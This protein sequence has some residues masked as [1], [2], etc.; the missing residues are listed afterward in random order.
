MEITD[1]IR[2][3]KYLNENLRGI[4]DA[5]IRYLY[6]LKTIYNFEPKVI[7]DI[8]SCVLHWYNIA[9]IIWPEAEIWCFEGNEECKVIYDEKGINYNIG[10][11]SD[12]DNKE[13]KYYYCNEHPGGN[14]YYQEIGSINSK[15]DFIN[16]KVK[17]TSKLDTVC[18]N[19][20]I[21]PPDLVKIDVQGAEM[22]VIKGGINNIL[23]T[24][25]LIV[26]MQH[27]EYNKGAP[28]VDITKPFIESLGFKCIKE[29]ITG[30]KY[31]DDYA[32][33]RF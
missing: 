22:D 1:S 6:E 8:G 31:D 5:H 29:K 26:E 19:K 10:L 33:F 28:K 24:K 4:P 23:K 17:Y 32:F 20:K 18:E 21:P 13:V 3:L 16:Y 15:N 27:T 11:L 2:H 9:H 12:E 25:H 30:S 7:Y 14:S